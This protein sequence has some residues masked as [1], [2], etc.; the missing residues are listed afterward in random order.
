MHASR[1]GTSSERYEVPEYFTQKWADPS[2]IS[3]LKVLHFSIYYW[4]RRSH[5]WITWRACWL[6]DVRRTYPFEK[7]ERPE[8]EHTNLLFPFSRFQ[9]FSVSNNILRIRHWELE[10]FP[11]FESPEPSNMRAIISVDHSIAL[12][13]CRGVNLESRSSC[14]LNRIASFASRTRC[15]KWWQFVYARSEFSRPRQGLKI[16]QKFYCF[17]QFILFNWDYTNVLKYDFDAQ[18]WSIKLSLHWNRRFWYW[19]TILKTTQILICN[20]LIYCCH[21]WRELGSRCVKIKFWLK[22]TN[23]K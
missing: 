5:V 22:Q 11:W 17:I 12:E 4:K 6:I 13:G 19:K 23:G 16:F 14:S 2:W 18:H 15:F 8:V 3:S 9:T 10:S 7:S 1:I 20:N 21:I